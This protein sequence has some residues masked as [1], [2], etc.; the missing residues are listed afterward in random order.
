M[1][2]EKIP[3]SACGDATGFLIVIDVLRAF[4]TAAY[5]FGAG[6][7]EIKLVGT[8]EEAL[9]LKKANA[10]LLLT[11]ELKGQ[12]IPGFDFGNSPYEISKADLEGKKLV[13][14][15][16]AGTQGVILSLKADEILTASFAVAEGTLREILRK[17]PPK[18]TFVITGT[19][20]GKADED[21]ALADYLEERLRGRKPD[22]EPYLKRVWESEDAVAFAQSSNH[23]T[24][25]N[26]VKTAL[27]IDRFP[28]AMRVHKENTLKTV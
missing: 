7:S 26:D 13:Q 28:F 3:L 24:Y 5:A 10:S 8:I 22:P 1:L 21:W 15:T 12:P 17:A 20:L 2:I 4:T 25:A 9:A 27:L 14:R 23:P 19:G 11:G 18:V 16:S 6:A